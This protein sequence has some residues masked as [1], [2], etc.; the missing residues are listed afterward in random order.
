MNIVA[1][2][3]LVFLVTFS[4]VVLVALVAAWVWRP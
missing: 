3:I 4:A 1:A 2:A